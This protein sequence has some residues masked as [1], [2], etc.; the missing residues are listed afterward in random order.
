MRGRFIAAVVFLA[1]CLVAGTAWSQT[2]G[3]TIKLKASEA[4]GTAEEGG[5]LSWRCSTPPHRLKIASPQIRM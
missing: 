4:P 5:R 3:L 1:A 2:P